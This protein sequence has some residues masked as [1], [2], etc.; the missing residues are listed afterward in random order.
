[1]TLNYA[2]RSHDEAMAV[3]HKQKRR[4]QEHAGGVMAIEGTE[5][6]T[7]GTVAASCPSKASRYGGLE[8]ESTAAG[9][10]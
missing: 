10:E 2:G 4:A 5:A 7:P 6:A 1:M 3:R 8:A 9:K